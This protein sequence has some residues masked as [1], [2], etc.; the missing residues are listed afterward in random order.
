MK[1]IIQIDEIIGFIKSLTALNKKGGYMNTDGNLD[2]LN[3]YECK[4]EKTEAATE[5]AMLEFRCN[6][7]DAVNHLV[8]EFKYYARYNDINRNELRA[9]L[10]ED[11]EEQL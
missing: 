9:I 4:Q 7:N 10:L 6:M 1:P 8:Q 2:A 11:I 3:R 5:K